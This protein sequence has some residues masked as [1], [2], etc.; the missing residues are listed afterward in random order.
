MNVGTFHD[1]P[2]DNIVPPWLLPC[3]CGPHRCHCHACL[4]PDLLCVCGLAY[5]N[6]PPTQPNP[7]FIIQFIEFAFCNDRF[8]PD[9][10]ALKTTKYQP[11]LDSI[12][13]HGW[14]IAPLIIITVGTRATTHLLSIKHLH[15]QFKIPKLRIKQTFTNINIIAIHHAMSI[16]LHKKRIENNQPLPQPHA[17]H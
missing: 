8:S 10:I 15:I 7:A 6:P 14:T 4:K 2:P 11:L 1:T 5:N 9:T 3:S 17:P 12:H 16:L 13:S